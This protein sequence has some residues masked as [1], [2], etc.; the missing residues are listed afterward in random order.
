[1]GIYNLRG[2]AL[3]PLRNPLETLN[4]FTLLAFLALSTFW[5]LTKLAKQMLNQIFSLSLS[6][7]LSIRLLPM[8]F[9]SLTKLD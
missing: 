7:Y 9:S 2:D 1:M 3:I 4:I 8:N 6:F 5:A